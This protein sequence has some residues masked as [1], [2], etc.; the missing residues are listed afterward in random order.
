[1]ANPPGQTT[2]RLQDAMRSAPRLLSA[3][4][5]GLACASPPGPAIEPVG[6]RGDSKSLLPA[7]FVSATQLNLLDFIAAERP[8]WLRTPDGR[9]AG[10]AVYVDDARLGGVSTLKTITLATVATVRYYE[11]TAAQQK[12]SSID[13]GPVIQVLTK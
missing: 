11:T 6:H 1:M 7:D 5:L 3:L 2:F 9:P 10:V 4:V 8:Q 12:F 13:R